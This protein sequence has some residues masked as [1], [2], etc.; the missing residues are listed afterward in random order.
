MGLWGQRS[1]W[2]LCTWSSWI[3]YSPLCVHSVGQICFRAAF[4]GVQAV[5]P[6]GGR[7]EGGAPSALLAV[8]ETNILCC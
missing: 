1:V 5:V 3:K 2:T 4:T 6:T 8:L 7:L